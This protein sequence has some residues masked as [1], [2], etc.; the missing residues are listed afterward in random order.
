MTQESA[1]ISVQPSAS[2]VVPFHG[3][4]EEMGRTRAT[5]HRW[6][7]EHPWLK[8]INIFGK[9][10]ISRA[11]IAEFERRAVAGELARDIK[12]DASE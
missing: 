9:L 8:T 10:Y 7:K 2:N 11:M 4:L 3:W 12:P 5:G 1:T 6:R